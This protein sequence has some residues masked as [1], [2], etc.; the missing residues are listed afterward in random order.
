MTPNTVSAW[1]TTGDRSL[2]LA[3][4]TD[5][6]FNSVAV[7][8]SIPVIEVDYGR[9]FQSVVGWG[10]AMTD[11]SAYLIHTK[12]DTQ[13]REA[14]LQELFGPEPGIGLSF[15]R[16]PMGASDFSQ[17]HYSYDDRPKGE[18]D[19]TLAHFS[20]DVDRPEKIPLLKRALA[21]NPELRL[22]GSPWSAPGWMKSSGSLI[23]GT[24]L[25]QFH[26]AFAEYFR[27]WIEAY[28]AEGLPIFAIT[29]QNEPHFE[30]GNYPGMR[31]S[32]VQRAAIIGEYVGPL[33]KRRSISTQI[34]DWDH[35]WDEPGSPLAVL[36]D[37]VAR[38]YVAAVAWHCYAGDISAQTQVHERHPDKDTY[39]TE[40]SGG[41]WAPIW[42]DNLRW[43]V[44]K[45]VI[46]NARGWAEG[47]ALW[48]L[49]LDEKYGPHLGG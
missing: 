13:Q 5:L 2:L 30:P 38:R 9:E 47:V 31:L 42:A 11:A 46:G 49:A 23:K 3:R 33:F 18:T 15:V 28:E 26:S 6:H 20:I 8:S 35:N 43:N 48:N 22:V 41:Q 19:S 25:P 40:C 32:P 36:A 4:Q 27:R 14:L 7:D 44:S 29:L 45:M 1:V 34:W 17:S 21:I 39:F 37:T 24:L 16:I 12:L 10:A